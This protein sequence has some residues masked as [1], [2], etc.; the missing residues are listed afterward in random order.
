MI[1]L[2]PFADKSTALGIRLR[3]IQIPGIDYDRTTY[4]FREKEKDD[5]LRDDFRFYI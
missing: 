4:T 2:A 5:T 3:G 1:V